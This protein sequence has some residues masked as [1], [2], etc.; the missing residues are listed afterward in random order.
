M[1]N[2]NYDPAQFVKDWLPDYE[3]KLVLITN[4]YVSIGQRLTK[5]AKEYLRQIMTEKYFHEALE[6]FAEA[7]KVECYKEFLKTYAPYSEITAQKAILNAPTPTVNN[8]KNK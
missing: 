2:K 1:E 8:L 5:N 4:E 3:T 7:Q 6:A